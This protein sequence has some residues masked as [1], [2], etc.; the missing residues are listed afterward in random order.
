MKLRPCGLKAFFSWYFLTKYQF[1]TNDGNN[2]N[3][4]LHHAGIA[5]LLRVNNK[6]NISPKSTYIVL[7][8]T[9]FTLA[10]LITN[11]I[12]CPNG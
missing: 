7:I 1:L 9:A 5:V 11:V 3:N 10:A 6:A 12:E 8:P 2:K 4:Y